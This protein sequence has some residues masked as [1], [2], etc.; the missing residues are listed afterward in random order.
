METACLGALLEIVEADAA[1]GRLCCGCL[2][3]AR[4]AAAPAAGPG[5]TSAGSGRTSGAAAAAAITAIA[6]LQGLVVRAAAF[7]A[8]LLSKLVPGSITRRSSHEGSKAPQPKTKAPSHSAKLHNTMRS[9][10]N[11]GNECGDLLSAG[12]GVV[13]QRSKLLL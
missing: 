13:R 7:A 3:A 8:A 11:S 2:A 12:V 5:C 10:S 4:A 9:K 1:S 6:R